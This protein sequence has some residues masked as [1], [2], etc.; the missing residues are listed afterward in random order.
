MKQALCSPYITEFYG[1]GV[2][3]GVDAPLHTITTSAGHFGVVKAEL[4]QELGRWPEIRA[5]LNEHCGYA[6]GRDEVLVAWIAGIPHYISDIGLRM[7]TPEELKLAQGFPADYIIDRYYDGTPV[8]K[9]Q[10]VKMIGNSVVPIMARKLV[11]ANVG[12]A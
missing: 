10:Q 7:L 11:A 3:S 5:L 1:T 12:A 8:S 2:A 4:S 9:T 6:L